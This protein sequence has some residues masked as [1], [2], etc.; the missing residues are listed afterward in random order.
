MKKASIKHLR[1][2]AWK[3]I[4]LRRWRDAQPPAPEY[5]DRLDMHAATRERMGKPADPAD[6][7][8]EHYPHGDRKV[9]FWRWHF[10]YSLRTPVA[11]P[12]GCL[13]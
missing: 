4:K 5:L 7:S 2:R 11:G 13:P 9:T 8:R 10:E 3:K 1:L 12:K 6:Y